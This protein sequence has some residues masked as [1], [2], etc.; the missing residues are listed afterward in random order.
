MF[1][2][3]SKEHFISFKLKFTFVALIEISDHL[4]NNINDV[5]FPMICKIKALKSFLRLYHKKTTFDIPGKKKKKKT[6]EKIVGKKE[7]K[8]GW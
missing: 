2:L 1:F 7:K 5:K 4:T 8:K 3:L 6:F